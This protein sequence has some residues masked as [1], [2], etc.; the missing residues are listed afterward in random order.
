MS[1]PPAQALS[2]QQL[3][4]LLA[5]LL[6][7]AEL[8]SAL[9]PAITSR[10]VI[11][12]QPGDQ[13]LVFSP[14]RELSSLSSD[15]CAEALRLTG[16]VASH[17]PSP[18]AELLHASPAAVVSPGGTAT[19]VVYGRHLSDAPAAKLFVRMRG[20]YLDVLS[21]DPV[22]EGD[23]SVDSS[24]LPQLTHGC[25]RM[26]VTVGG[27]RGPGLAAVEMQYGGG[28][29]PGG[30]MMPFKLRCVR[31]QAALSGWAPQSYSSTSPLGTRVSVLL[32]S[33]CGYL[34]LSTRGLQQRS[35]IP[36][37]IIV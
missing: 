32:R 26:R 5:E 18:A 8:V 19:F 27:V 21:C 30:T 2:T 14:S 13:L 16:V 17:L 33:C 23:P 25:Q 10:C 15:D 12:A 31:D 37:T 9:G 6:P 35:C 7:T 34:R 3:D 1:V 29:G 20:R 28:G 24:T 22:D 36:P 4:T 11:T